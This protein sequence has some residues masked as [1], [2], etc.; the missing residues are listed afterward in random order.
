MIL[1][2]HSLVLSLQYMI[3]FRYYKVHSYK[4]MHSWACK[5]TPK[6]TQTL[7]SSFDDNKNM[8]NQQ[9]KPFFFS[10]N[11]FNVLKLF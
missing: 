7:F 8:K 9:F 10:I 11:E 2:F 4:H 1:F 3:L 6:D 5:H